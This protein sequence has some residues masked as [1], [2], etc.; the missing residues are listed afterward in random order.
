VTRGLVIGKFY[1]PHLGH[2]FLIDTASAQVERLDVLICA[3]PEQTIPG[4]LRAQWLREIH[5]TACVR[6]I[7]DP[8]EDENS[9]FWA[10]Y[11]IQILGRAPDVV[12][13][14]EDYGEAYARFLN[15][16][17]VMV[18]RKRACVPISARAIRNAP[19]RYWDY[20]E[21][22]VR[23]YYAKRI[24]IVGAESTGT[25]TLA[26]ELAAHYNTVWV[27]EYG[28]EYCENLQAAGL[29]LWT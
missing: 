13:T 19:S 7:E 27:P 24:S 3:R 17:H 11:T 4:E 2:K 23:A 12:F 8:G 14:S 29:D 20:M 10:K 9:Q 25:T 6:A 18:D 26:R 1:P 15:C 22:C 16:R 28:R 21:P 5:P